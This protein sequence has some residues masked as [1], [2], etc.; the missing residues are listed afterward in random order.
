[1]KP[2]GLPPLPLGCTHEDRRA[3]EL[4]LRAAVERVRRE[5]ASQAM[6]GAQERGRVEGAE[7]VSAWLLDSLPEEAL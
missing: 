2:T 6:D 5:A 7:R 3:W 4:W 1:V